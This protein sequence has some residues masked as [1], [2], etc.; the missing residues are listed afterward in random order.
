MTSIE[1]AAIAAV[2]MAHA[3]QPSKQAVRD[4]LKQQIAAK[5]P[6]PSGE[7]I[8]RQL[9]FGLLNNKSADCAR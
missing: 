6:P 5:L 4:W 9:G 1:R 2:G 8:R 7:E 3:S